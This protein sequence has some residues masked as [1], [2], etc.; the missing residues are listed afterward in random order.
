MFVFQSILKLT[1]SDSDTVST[2]EKA[3]E[4]I[5]EVILSIS[6]C[7]DQYYL[8]ETDRSEKNMNCL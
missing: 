6:E 7:S 4:A 8:A 5:H 2:L 1:D 3:I